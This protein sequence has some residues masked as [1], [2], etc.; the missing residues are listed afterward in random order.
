MPFGASVNG[1]TTAFRVWA[2]KARRVRLQIVGSPAASDMRRE[3]GGTWSLEA[4]AQAGDRYFYIV[5]DSKPLPDPV[6]R[7]LPEGVHGPTE[8]VDPAAFEWTDSGWRGLGLREYVLYELH[9]GTFTP[10]GTF[11]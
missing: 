1:G 7:F 11:E 5:D 2:P 6:S 3:A 10:Q 9:V 8:I 4:A